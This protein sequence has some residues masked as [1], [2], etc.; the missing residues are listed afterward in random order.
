MACATSSD[1][2][3]RQDTCENILSSPQKVLSL[4]VRAL[5]GLYV[6][7]AAVRSARCIAEVWKH[8]DSV[9]AYVEAR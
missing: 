5:A 6:W 4:P 2:Y 1:F 9:P 3:K 8:L 7:S